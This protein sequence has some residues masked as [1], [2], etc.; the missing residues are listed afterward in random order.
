VLNKLKNSHLFRVLSVNS[1]SVGISFI[2][3]IAS[4]KIISFFLGTS[5]MAI[6]GSFRNFTTMLKSMSTLGINNSVVKLFVENKED[7]NELSKIYSTFFWIFLA[8]SSFLGVIVALF[9]KLI[10]KLLFYTDSY[11]LA[12]CFF[13]ILLPLIVINI[14]WISIYNGFERFKKIVIIQIIS[15]IFTFII[16]A[17]LIWKKHLIGSL[18]SVVISEIIMVIITFLYVRKDKDFFELNLQKV[19]SYNHINVIKKFSVM[20]LLSAVIAPLTL[21]IIRNLIVKEYSINQAGI[22]DATNRLSSFYMLFFSSGLTMYYMPKLASLKTDSEFKNELAAYFKSLVPLFAVML[23]CIFVLKETIL[24]IA[25]TKEFYQVKD[26]LL[27][28]LMGDFFRIM[29]LSFGFQ[30]VVKTMMKRYFIIEITFNLVYVLLANYL[31]KLYTVEG[32][33]QAYF[34]ANVICFVLV[35]IMFRKLFLKK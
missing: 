35:L 11:F 20:A 34:Y 13:G 21:I 30:I 8:L 27:W 15:N 10:S 17:V 26:I 22:W 14:F 6:L 33:L 18:F 19:I 16:T 25:F 29:T 9:S 31:M 2:I 4:S 23:V 24:K 1:L 28:Q 12:I 7:K 5:G 32:V 3:G